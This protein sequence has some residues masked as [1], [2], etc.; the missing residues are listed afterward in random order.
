MFDMVENVCFLNLVGE[1][2]RVELIG[3]GRGKRQED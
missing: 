1:F 2:T 3:N